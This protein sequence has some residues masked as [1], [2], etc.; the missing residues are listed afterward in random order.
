[1]SFNPDLHQQTQEVKF[2]SK[3]LRLSYP[4]ICFYNVAVCSD[5]RKHVGVTVDEK[6]NFMYHFK[7]KIF[8]AAKI[9]PIIEN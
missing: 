9:I 1:M 5:F 2:V 8:Q 4:Q 7:E 3:I 6:L